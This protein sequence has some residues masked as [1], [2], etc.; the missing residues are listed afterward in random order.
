MDSI[1]TRHMAITST[2]HMMDD[3]ANN[4]NDTDVHLKLSKTNIVNHD[5]IDCFSLTIWSVIMFV[6]YKST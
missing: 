4:D 1:H 2:Y 3:V 5:G 6:D